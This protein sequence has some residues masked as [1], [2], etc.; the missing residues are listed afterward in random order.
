M[1]IIE[2][3]GKIFSAIGAWFGYAKARSDLKNSPDVRAAVI[4]QKEADADATV[5]RDIVTRDED[6]FRKDIS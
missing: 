3:I 5:E 6:A 4:G 1:V 2:T